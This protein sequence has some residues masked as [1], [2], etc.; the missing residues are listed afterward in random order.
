MIRVYNI[1]ET[2]S[3]DVNFHQQSFLLKTE[4]TNLIYCSIIS[5]KKRFSFCCIAFTGVQLV[6]NLETVLCGH[7]GWVTNIKWHLSHDGKLYL[8]SSSMDKTIILW[9]PLDDI[10]N[11]AY[12][13]GEVG[14]N[15]IG[16]L[17]CCSIPQK[18]LIMGY[19]F[20][21]SVNFWEQMVEGQWHTSVPITGHFNE[22]TDLVWEPKGEYFLT[23]STDQ[24]TRLHSYWKDGKGS[25][26]TWHE[27]GRPQVHG[28]DLKCIA[29]AGRLKFISGADEKVIRLFNATKYFIDSWRLIAS[30]DGETSSFENEEQIAE[31]A[32]VPALGLSN[33]AVYDSSQ[34]NEELKPKVQPT[35]PTEEVLQKTLWP[36]QQKVLYS[37][38]SYNY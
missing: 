34:I 17:G 29:M 1:K 32:V 16:F 7:E 24:T 21:G 5:L 13:F 25:P 36:E 33:S 15:A 28:Y 26:L 10:W 12:R 38:H 27:I 30:P 14:G 23:C 6:A 11:E 35:P 19:S 3:E 4:G 8:L 18:R 9:E 20:S 31:C 2:Q 22:V 37:N